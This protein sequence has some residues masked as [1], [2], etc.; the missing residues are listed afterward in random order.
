MRTPW[1]KEQVEE[2]RQWHSR[3]LQELD[4]PPEVVKELTRARES[5]LSK[6]KTK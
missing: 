2:F 4:Y 6:V 5:W 1:T 3:R